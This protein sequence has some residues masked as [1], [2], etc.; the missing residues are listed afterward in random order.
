MQ[1]FPP[2]DVP[3]VSTRR[4]VRCVRWKNLFCNQNFQNDKIFSKFLEIW[5]ECALSYAMLGQGSVRQDSESIMP[6]FLLD[7]FLQLDFQV[8]DF[9]LCKPE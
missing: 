9:L 8:P 6:F 1:I 4:V 5:T 2:E 3:N 7:A